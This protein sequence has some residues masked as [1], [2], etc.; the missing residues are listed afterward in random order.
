MNY[1][2]WETYEKKPWYRRWWFLLIVILVM[3]ACAG[4]VLVYGYLS[5]KFANQVEGYD[6]S[7]LE[8]MESASVIYD[9]NGVEMGKIF[10][11]NRLPIHFSEIP[12]NMVYAIVAE[13]D[14]LDKAQALS[15]NN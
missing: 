9:R 12:K 8:T 15:L 6:L 2:S 7:K 13:E 11:Q 10:I 4:S 14:V 5:Y 1:Y 3:I